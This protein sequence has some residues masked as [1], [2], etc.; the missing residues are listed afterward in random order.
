MKKRKKDDLKVV[1]SH[2]TEV[3]SLKQLL[4]ENF[5]G[6][7]NCIV[8]PR[9]INAEFN[10]LAVQ[11]YDFAA[12]RLPFAGRI[13]EHFTLKAF[14]K[15]IKEKGAAWSNEIA[16]AANIIGDDFQDLAEQ[17][18]IVQLRLNTKGNQREYN[19]YFRQESVS[20]VS[21]KIVINYNRP[22]E[23]LSSVEETAIQPNGLVQIENAEKKAS[24]LSECG[25]VKFACHGAQGTSPFIFRD[26]Q[27]KG[28]IALQLVAYPKLGR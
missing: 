18:Y 14:A 25:I 6:M 3:D 26:P 20:G 19:Q 8:L 28:Q 13:T 22:M 2:T 12:A 27:P 7:R 24:L 1:Y 9:E 23:Y 4:E 15:D 17:K 10:R 21:E 11:L 5:T 16:R